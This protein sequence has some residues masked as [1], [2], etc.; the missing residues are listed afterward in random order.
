[1]CAAA[2]GKVVLVGDTN[3]GK[4]A[5]VLRYSLGDYRNTESTIGANSVVCGVKLSGEKQVNLNVW[6]TAGHDDFRCLLPMYTRD[7]EVAIVVFD[8]SSKESFLHLEDWLSR[9]EDSTQCRMFLVGNKI[10]LTPE[11]KD[12]EIETFCKTRNLDYFVTSAKTGEGIDVLF[13]AIAEVVDKNSTQAYVPQQVT[14]RQETETT[15][16]ERGSKQCC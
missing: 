13:Y 16:D 10:D 14:L 12:T 3:V 4:T 7:A 15:N 5:I 11:V 1:M 9:F 8:V 2:R 6:D